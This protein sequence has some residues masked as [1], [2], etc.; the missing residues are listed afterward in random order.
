[1]PYVAFTRPA[2]ERS[3][4]KIP[5]SEWPAII[6]RHSAG[7]AL[8]SIGK[9]YGCSAPNILYIVR[10]ARGLRGEGAAGPGARTRVAREQWAGVYERHRAGE[11]IAALAES[12]GCSKRTV[13]RI[14][15]DQRR[16]SEGAG[17]GTQKG[18]RSRGR[19]SD[20]SAAATTGSSPTSGRGEGESRLVV[21]AA[22]KGARR[23]G[24]DSI[25]PRAGA[26]GRLG[27]PALARNGR[28][29]VAEA[30]AESQDARVNAAAPSSM[31]DER[32]RE[33]IT[34]DV[35][36]FLSAF[37]AALEHDTPEIRSAL[38]KASD[39]LLRAGANT[40]T[41]IERLEESGHKREAS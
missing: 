21:L 9:S 19:R 22:G 2:E 25:E 26:A 37:N 23:R 3:V 11:P 5:R 14:I 24:S 1:L 30:L 15:Q 10:K 29:D 16:A 41:E 20:E 12:L 33:R 4:S 8:A 28:A 13:S 31:L 39:R 36:A 6:E 27:R 35:A 34:S 18:P 7:E 32:T 40:R 38:L 17:V